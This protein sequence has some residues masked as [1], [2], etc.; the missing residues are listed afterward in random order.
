MVPVKLSWYERAVKV[1]QFHVEHIKQD[2]SWSYR[3]TAKELHMSVGTV[4]NDLT[5]ASWLKTYPDLVNLKTAAEALT[6]IKQKKFKLR[7]S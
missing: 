7:I 2:G 6:F 1:N 4:C 5:I 3:D